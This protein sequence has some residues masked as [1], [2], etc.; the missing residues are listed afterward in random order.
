MGYRSYAVALKKSRVVTTN[1]SV[2]S[3]D[4]GTFLARGDQFIRPDGQRF[5]VAYGP[6]GERYVS[7]SINGWIKCA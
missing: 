1:P 6:R 4:D 7:D 3:L 2:V 5:S